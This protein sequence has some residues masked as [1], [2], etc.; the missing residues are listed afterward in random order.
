MRHVGHLA[1]GVGGFGDCEDRLVG[2]VLG[3]A[4]GG[5]LGKQHL[6]VGHGL[7]GRWGIEGP[8]VA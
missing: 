2:A 7:G 5:G 1:G 3:R 8:V 6:L 4:S